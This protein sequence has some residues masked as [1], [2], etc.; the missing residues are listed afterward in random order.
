M[1][2]ID[3]RS[4]LKTSLLTTAALS[5]PVRSWAQPVGAN[6]IVQMKRAFHPGEIS[7]ARGET[8][9][10]N[11]RDDFIHQVYVK[12]DVLRFDSDE[13]PPGQN[14]QIQFT[15]AGTFEVRCHIHPKMNL[16]VHVK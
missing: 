5:L 9:T 2:T 8:L 11:N 3:R 16:T 13:Q 15:L 7:L 1:K 12:S 14:I 4:F 6:T 10:F